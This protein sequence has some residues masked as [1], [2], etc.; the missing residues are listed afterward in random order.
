MFTGHVIEAAPAAADADPLPTVQQLMERGLYLNAREWLDA[1]EADPRVEARLTAVRLSWHLGARRRAMA[2]SL[3]TWRRHR[4]D[5]AACIEMLRTVASHRGPYRAWQWLARHGLPATATPAQRAE[6]HSFQAGILGTLRD[7]AEAQRHYRLAVELDP[8]EAWTQVEWAHVCEQRDEYEQALAHARKALDLKPG[9]RP[10]VQAV[11]H[12]CTLLGRDDEALALLA[13]QVRGTQAAS[14]AMPLFELQFER[15]LLVDALHTLDRCRRYLV[16]ADRDMAMWLRARRADLLL[17]M[18]CLDEARELARA[19]G[20]PFHDGLADRLAAGTGQPRRVELPVGFVRQHFNT[21]APATLSAISRYWGRPARHLEIAEAICYDGTPHHSE[22][23]W[24]EEQGF[25]AIEFTVDWDVSRALIDAGVPFTL[26][27]VGTQSAHLQAVIGY[28]ELRESLLIRDPFKRTHG[29]FD[30]RALF[31][32]HRPHGPRGMVLLPPEAFHRV[33]AIELPE[34]RLWDASHAFML[35]LVSHDRARAA[36]HAS[37]LE[38]LAPGHRLAVGARRT[39]AGYDGNE[40][41]LLALTEQLLQAFPDE[42]NLMLSKAASMSL[43]ASREECAQ[44]WRSVR[45]SALADVVVAVRHAQF[46]A[47]DLREHEAVRRLLV[48]TLC[49]HPTDAAAWIT[50]AGVLWQAGARDEAL[51]HYRIGTCLQPTHEGYAESY[52]RAAHALGRTHEGLQHLEQRAEQWRHRAAGPT[53]TLFVQLEALDRT[54]EAFD[55]LQHAL[56]ARSDDPDLLMFAAEAHLRYG[57]AERSDECLARAESRAR[58]PTWLRLQALR[59]R[60]QGDVERALALAR[61]ACEAEPLNVDLHRLVADLLMQG[62]GRDEALAH[63][64]AVAARHAHHFELHRL[65]YAWCCDADPEAAV[66]VLHGMLAHSPH[67]AWT[68]RE[69]AI[70]LALLRRYDDALAQ[71]EAALAM[72]PRHSES[73]STLAF[74]HLRQGRDEDA[75]RHLESAVALSVDN[76]YAVRTLIELAPQLSARERA[77]AFVR[78]ELLTQVTLGDG[79]LAFQECARAIMPAEALLA[80][81][82]DMHRQRP[83]LWQAWIALASQ[84]ARMQRHDQAMALLD[85]AARRFAL[86][87]RVQLEQAGSLLATGQ[88]D[89]ARECLRRA[90]QINPAWHAAVRMYVDSVLDE[91]TGFERAMQVLEPALRRVPDNA[92]LRALRGWVRW[93]AG[94]HDEALADLQAAVLLQPSLH[95]GW[96]ALARCARELGRPAL[97]VEVAEAVCRQRPG[98]PVAWLRQAEHVQGL[99]DA[100]RAIDR[101]LALDPRHQGLH[102]ARLRLLL[103]AGRHDEV[104]RHVDGSPWGEAPPAAVAVYKARVAMA[105]G[106]HD[107]AAAALTALLQRDGSDA[108]LWRELADLHDRRDQLQSYVDAARHLVRLAPLAALSHAYLGH[109]LLRCGEAEPATT[110][111]EQALRLDPSYAFA[112]L[113]LVDLYLQSARGADAH[114]VLETLAR[115]DRSV[116]VMLRQLRVAVAS[117]RQAEALSAWDALLAVAELAQ[118]VCEAAWDE[119]RGAGWHQAA[120]ARIEAAI[121]AGACATVAARIWLQHVPAGRLPGARARRVRRQLASDPG[122]A[123]KRAQLHMLAES[124]DRAGLKRFMRAQRPVLWRDDRCWGLVGYALVSCQQYRA[125]VDWM[126]DA[127]HRAATPSWVRVNRCLALRQLGQVARAREEVSRLLADERDQPEAL[128][129]MAVDTALSGSPAEVGAVLDRVDAAD[130]DAYYRRL[131]LAAR[132]CADALAAGD[133][134]VALERFSAVRQGCGQDRATRRVLA[135]LSRRLVRECTP[136]WLRPW[137]ALQFAMAWE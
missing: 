122:H 119:L 19:V 116:P 73:H 6:W 109:A 103:A 34:Q 53:L 132:A 104:V 59:S 89:A 42:P 130:V 40:A 14:L 66:E 117:G 100:L 26:T 41:E 50:M 35:A 136:A 83:E 25:R 126:A 137:R 48:R 86:L 77:L 121:G 30:A 71:A 87:P 52:M 72:A 45:D 61:E 127:D 82:S 51:A 4:D 46:M 57:H 5:A 81:L 32:S 95:W 65:L 8:D 12:Y 99:D 33:A 94:A 38:R 28:D 64:R 29:E 125:A 31:E 16:L 133:S 124:G 129:W 74:V 91:G 11:A 13:A 1:L 123:L 21:C 3:A 17:R 39:L 47:E 58:R 56:A 7:F 134:R 85:E 75:R 110:A 36:E 112:G 113:H 79:L 43:L 9:Y 80:M 96:E 93:R 97:P 44:W 105:Q 62:A 27:T 18:G 78:G 49:V 115:H 69:L 67:S 135:G 98:D 111:L 92:D 114:A 90:L 22:R 2:R 118:P 37:Q 128:A 24:A 106:R 131:L 54:G 76:D 10:A 84:L 70:R 108:A 15:G 55:R 107:D 102:E 60:E 20:T 23:R 101:G 68:R 63:L 120:L 88:R